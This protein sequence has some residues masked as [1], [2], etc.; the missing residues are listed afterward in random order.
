[1]VQPLGF[2]KKKEGE[3]ERVSDRERPAVEVP[4]TTRRRRRVDRTLCRI[5]RSHL[6]ISHRSKRTTK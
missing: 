6:E 5:L 3:R 2:R 4:D 1:M